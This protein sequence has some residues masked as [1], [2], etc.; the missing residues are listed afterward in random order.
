ML[1]E[2]DLEIADAWIRESVL[3]KWDHDFDDVEKEGPR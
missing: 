2:R 3:D 1:S